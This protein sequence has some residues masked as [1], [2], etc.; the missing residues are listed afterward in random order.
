MRGEKY[1]Y[2]PIRYPQP[3]HIEIPEEFESFNSAVEDHMIIKGHV[4]AKHE[5][6]RRFRERER[7]EYTEL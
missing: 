1:Y 7:R 2:N 5:A 3:Y 4:A 6:K